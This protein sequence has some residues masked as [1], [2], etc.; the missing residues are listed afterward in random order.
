MSEVSDALQIIMIS[1]QVFG[2][3]TKLT[4]RAALIQMKLWNTLYLSKWKGNT[5]LTLVRK[6]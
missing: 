5:H 6:I 2:V 4:Y 3:A 1:G